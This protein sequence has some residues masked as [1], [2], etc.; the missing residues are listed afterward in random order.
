MTLATSYPFLEIF[1]SIALFFLWAIWIWVAV[2]VLVDVFAR[3]DISGWAKAGWTL[4]VIV[5]PFVG[6]LIYLVVNGNAMA[7][8][9][10]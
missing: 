7:T 2:V 1:G 3:S 8:R 9:R 10:A 4:L 6:I 5:F